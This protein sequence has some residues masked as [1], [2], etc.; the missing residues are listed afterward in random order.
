MF[1]GADVL[2][3]SSASG[4]QT[5]PCTEP[6]RVRRTAPTPE[7]D[8]SRGGFRPR[9]RCG[10]GPSAAETWCSKRQGVEGVIKGLAHHHEM[11]D[12]LQ[13]VETTQEGWSDT[14]AKTSVA[15][16][17]H[18]KKIHARHVPSSCWVISHQRHS[19]FGSLSLSLCLSVLT[20]LH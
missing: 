1:G 18:A 10:S 5:N 13:V 7:N 15:N 3:Y 14:G 2:F 9:T 16:I 6:T 20:R 8:V 12:A 11:V 19:R 4:L 17:T